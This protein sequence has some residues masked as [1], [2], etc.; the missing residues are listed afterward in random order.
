MNRTDQCPEC[1]GG[2]LVPPRGCT[3]GGN[4]HTCTPAICGRCGGSGRARCVPDRSAM[5]GN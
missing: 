5:P 2:G 1:S 3:Y 4:V